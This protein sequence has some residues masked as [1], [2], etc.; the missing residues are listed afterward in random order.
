MSVL[1]KCIVL[2]VLAIA[3]FFPTV[4]Q[5]QEEA[6]I[7]T[8]LAERDRDIKAVLAG[9][10]LTDQEKDSLRSIV[11][12]LILFEAMGREALGE[13]WQPLT[14]AQRTDFVETFSAIVREQSLADLDPYRATVTINDVKVDGTQGLA[15][16]TAL[17][18]DVTTVVE[19][20]LHLR[21]D[22]WWITDISLDGV[23]TADGYARSFQSAIR[24]RG[25]DGLMKSL[26]KRL[27]RI[28]G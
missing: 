28:T 12:D 20:E 17:Y 19:Y 13:Y 4:S 15:T 8:L 10:P 24:K 2:I 18:N 26:R 21:D 9:D 6:R 5:A 22:V 7:R 27:A 11:N 16:T 14:E 23:S 1:H 3:S 25:F